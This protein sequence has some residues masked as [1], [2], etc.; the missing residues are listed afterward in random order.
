MNQTEIFH[1]PEPLPDN[2]SDVSELVVQLKADFGIVVD[3]M[4]D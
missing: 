2:L 3:L 1:N 4:I